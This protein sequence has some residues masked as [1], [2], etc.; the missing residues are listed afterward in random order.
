ML[1]KD[2]KEIKY[3]INVKYLGHIGLQVCECISFY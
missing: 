1:V 3:D 2:V